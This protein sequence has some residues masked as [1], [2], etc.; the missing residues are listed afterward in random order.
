MFW[1]DEFF[2]ACSFV[3]SNTLTERMWVTAKAI[4]SMCWIVGVWIAQTGKRVAVYRTSQVQ[5]THCTTATTTNKAYTINREGDRETERYS[6]PTESA[7]VIA[8]AMLF[9]KACARHWQH[10]LSNKY[11]RIHHSR[12]WCR[13]ELVR[14]MAQVILCAHAALLSMRF[15]LC[16]TMSGRC[17]SQYRYVSYC[18]LFFFQLHCIFNLVLCHLHSAVVLCRCR[19]EQTLNQTQKRNPNGDCNSVRNAIRLPVYGHR[20]NESN[21][22]ETH[23][24][25]LQ[26]VYSG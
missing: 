9:R 14:C 5:R 13:I 23:S 16:Y 6:E 11:N 3:G 8:L 21:K 7:L 2:G 22:H 10:D 19:R 15:S 1:Y 20:A 17:E 18:P 12:C 4:Y 25:H 24:L 26:P